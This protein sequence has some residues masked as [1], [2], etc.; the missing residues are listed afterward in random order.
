VAEID[1]PST[2]CME[3]T[4]IAAGFIM[5]DGSLGWELDKHQKHRFSGR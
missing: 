5:G 4:Q 2:E 3:L 1:S